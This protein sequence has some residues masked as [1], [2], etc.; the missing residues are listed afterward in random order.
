VGRSY[1]KIIR[2]NSQS[3]KGG[4]AYIMESYFDIKLPKLMHAEF[5]QIIQ[6]ET[7]TTGK[8]VDPE[9]MMDLFEEEYTSKT[10]P[11][12]FKDCEIRT[13]GESTR[14]IAKINYAGESLNIEGIGNGPLDALGTAIKSRV[15][16]DFKLTSFS[17]HALNQT[18]ASKAIAYIG[19][20]TNR[21]TVFGVGIDANISIASFKALFS[22]LNRALGYQM[23]TL[24][25][26]DARNCHKRS[27]SEKY[28]DNPAQKRAEL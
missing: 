16:G 22:A 14:V 25:S 23:E 2:I 4:V 19:I 7:D 13:R 8:D 5:G 20:E 1:E 10:A 11:I 15:F 27:S 28:G 17:Q 21:S 26:E 9:R 24:E 12:E 3:G 6:H 18:T